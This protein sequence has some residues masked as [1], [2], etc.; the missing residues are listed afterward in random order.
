MDRPFPIILGNDL[1]IWYPRGLGREP[2]GR[3]CVGMA[4]SFLWWAKWDLLKQEEKKALQRGPSGEASEGMQR[5]SSLGPPEKQQ[6]Q[7]VNLAGSYRDD[8]AI[9]VPGPQVACQPQGPVTLNKWSDMYC[10]QC[11]KHCLFTIYSVTHSF[12]LWFL[13]VPLGATDIWRMNISIQ[14]FTVRI[15]MFW[16]TH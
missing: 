5:G 9:S 1:A 15:F 13:R 16:N 2:L 4:V 7:L 14:G 11:G 10:S 3:S 12:M 8:A 6:V